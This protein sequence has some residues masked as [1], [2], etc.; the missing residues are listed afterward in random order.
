MITRSP[1]KAQAEAA[2]G[3]EVKV[4]NGER[5]KVRRRVVVRSGGAENIRE[6]EVKIWAGVVAAAECYWTVMKR[7]M[8]VMMEV[9]VDGELGFH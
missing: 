7:W 9:N 6:I 3:E 5:E 2:E 1:R 8:W 4:E